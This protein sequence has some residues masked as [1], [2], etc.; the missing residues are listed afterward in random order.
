[1]WIL[2]AHLFLS[3][4]DDENLLEALTRELVYWKR[5]LSG[6]I[7]I[8]Y[9]D[10]VEKMA[11]YLPP[12]DEKNFTLPLPELIDLIF[13]SPKKPI[14]GLLPTDIS[15]EKKIR[16]LQEYYPVIVSDYDSLTE[17]LLNRDYNQITIWTKA[18]TLRNIRDL[19]NDS[20]RESVVA[21]MFSPEGILQE[22]AARVVAGS[23]LKLFG[24]VSLRIPANSKTWL[25]KIINFETNEKELLFEKTRF[26]SSVFENIPEDYLLF[27]ARAMKHTENLTAETLF[28]SNGNIIWYFGK[29]LNKPEFCRVVSE[30]GNKSNIINPAES[31]YSYYVLPLDSVKEFHTLYPEHSFEILKYIDK[32]EETQR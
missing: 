1:V 4:R 25:E 17:D 22:E 31:D 32:A 19:S 13:T 18:S 23:D 14:L 6:L 28:Y 5:F 20:L 3:K 24:S 2:S 21:L 27:L 16:V 15:Q 29:D 26:L 30:A 7:I 9:S 8:G 12:A 10:N 11:G